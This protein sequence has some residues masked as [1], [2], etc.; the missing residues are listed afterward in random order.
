MQHIR[1]RGIFKDIFSKRKK[2]KKKKKKCALYA[3]KYNKLGI[4]QNVQVVI[5]VVKTA[6]IC[7]DVAIK[8][9]VIFNLKK[10]KKEKKEK[11]I[12]QNNDTFWKL[13]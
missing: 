4:N 1:C 8:D 11:V 10:K 7:Q 12:Q 6:I 2:K 3:I 5:L 13:Q 9:I